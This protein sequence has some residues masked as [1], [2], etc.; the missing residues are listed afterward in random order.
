MSFEFNT[1][2]S[3]ISSHCS[4]NNNTF[5]FHHKTKVSLCVIA[6]IACAAAIP[7]GPQPRQIN[8]IGQPQPINPAQDLAAGGEQDLKASS[9][10]GY[11]Y[12]GGLGGG[13]PGYS[14]YYSSNY[15]GGGGYGYPYY[16]RYYSCKW[17]LILLFFTH[18]FIFLPNCIFVHNFM[19]NVS[20][21]SVS[22]LPW[23]W[24]WWTLWRILLRLP[25]LNEERAYCLHD[26]TTRYFF[27]Y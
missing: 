3:S 26:M 5:F 22:L 12:Y 18:L 13:Y 17:L 16:S 10:Y 2:S 14:P 7:A 9:S 24:R 8:P 4:I 6:I 15:Y 23:L 21:S 27:F 11:G 19:I 20:M 25:R 1:I